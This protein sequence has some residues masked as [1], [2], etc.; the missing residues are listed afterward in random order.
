MPETKQYNETTRELVAR[1][2]NPTKEPFPGYREL[3]Q[4]SKRTRNTFIILSVVA[5]IVAAAL[6]WVGYTHL[7]PAL[8][9]EPGELESGVELPLEDL[10]SDAIPVNI[11]YHKMAVPS[12]VSMYGLTSGEVLERLGPGWEE[13]RR[14]DVV[15]GDNPAVVLLVTLTFK[16]DVASI[17]G[18][19]PNTDYAV[20]LEKA[21]RPEANLYLSLNADGRVIETLFTAELDM[22]D[23]PTSVAFT[24]LLATDGFVSQVLQWAGVQPLG[25]TYQPP[26]FDS[27]VSYDYPDLPTRKVTKQS[28]AFHGRA[29]NQGFPTAWV[30][31]VTYDFIPPVASVDGTPNARRILNIRLA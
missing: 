10:D 14:I 22:L 18:G 12:L 2:D 6:A 8:A 15:G 11:V 3:A 1:M 4:K 17:E 26:D 28:S 21:K 31:T 29:A 13:T 25:F 27:T 9:G 20:E 24:E 16:P 23:Y 19:G 5:L 30:V 7:L